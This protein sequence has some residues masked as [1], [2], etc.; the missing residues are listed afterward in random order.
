MSMQL[1][2]AAKNYSDPFAFV[3]AFQA[4]QINARH[5]ATGVRELLKI[6][7]RVNGTK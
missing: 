7:Y 5:G 4:V 3:L 2:K 1:R 6:W